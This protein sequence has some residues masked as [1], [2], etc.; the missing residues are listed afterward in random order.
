[1]STKR[2]EETWW[3]FTMRPHDMPLTNVFVGMN[4]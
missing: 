2:K 4:S 3:H 1:M